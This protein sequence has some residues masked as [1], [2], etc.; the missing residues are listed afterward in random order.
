VIVCPSCGRTVP[1]GTAFCPYCSDPLVDQA[2]IEAARQTLARVIWAER[3]RDLH[4]PP[5]VC[6]ALQTLRETCED[7]SRRRV[8]P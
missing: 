8:R 7:H 6:D 3:S 2:V 4:L 5:E 1:N